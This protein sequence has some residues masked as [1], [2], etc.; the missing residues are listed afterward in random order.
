MKL[1]KKGTAA[2]AKGT[3]KAL[4]LLNKASGK[5]EPMREVPLLGEYV[6]DIQDIVAMLDDYYHGRYR[7]LPFA[8]LAGALG[9]V[10]YLVSPIDLIPDGIP[11]LGFIDDAF[12]INIVLNLCVDTELSRYRKWRGAAG[13]LNAN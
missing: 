13:E 11:V 6:A 12:I 4:A 2:A 7:K 10:A 1:I 3:A 9:I 8:V 5:L